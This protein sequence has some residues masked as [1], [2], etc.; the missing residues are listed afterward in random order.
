MYIFI[1]N[2]HNVKEETSA[3]TFFMYNKSYNK[4]KFDKRVCD[5]EKLK[6]YN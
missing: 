1:Y 5:I 4:V 2:Y 6:N 3:V